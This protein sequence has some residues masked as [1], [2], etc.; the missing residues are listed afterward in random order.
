MH[1]V[2]DLATI[3][4]AQTM[5]SN[6]N[7]GE[8]ISMPGVW[9]NCIDTFGQPIRKLVDYWLPVI[10]INGDESV[11]LITD[12]NTVTLLRRPGPYLPAC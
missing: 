3:E 7:A 9:V 5:L 12:H 4:L 6:A 11:F 10:K 8:I 2:N 1:V